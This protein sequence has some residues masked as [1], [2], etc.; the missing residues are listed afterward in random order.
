MPSELRNMNKLS[1]S[2]TSEEIEAYR[3]ASDRLGISMNQFVRRAA[4]LAIM[5]DKLRDSPD[6]FV[7]LRT[8]GG[9]EANQHIIPPEKL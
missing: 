1:V 2:V 4:A 5:V 9:E 7:Y 3:D 8:E 6:Q